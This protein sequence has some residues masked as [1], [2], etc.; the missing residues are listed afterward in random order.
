MRS[1][2][3][4]KQKPQISNFSKCNSFRQYKKL[5]K[6]ASFMLNFLQ[7]EIQIL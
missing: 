4:P 6:K 5:A 1:Y 7:A 3:G 2:S